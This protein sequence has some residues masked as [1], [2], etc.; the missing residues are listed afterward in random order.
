MLLHCSTCG[1]ELTGR[2]VCSRCGT[3]VGLEAGLASLRNRLQ[4][5]LD[6]GVLA[7]RGALQ[8]IHFLW[9]CALVPIFV[10]P[11]CVSLVMA[12][13]AMR[14]AESR[15]ASSHEWVALVSALNIVVS[16]LFLYKL[17]FSPAEVVV[18]L[19]AWMRWLLNWITGPFAPR[20][21]SVKVTP[22]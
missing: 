12:V 17:H 20:P 14:G 9:A 15:S 4:R 8:P 19:S 16:L 13:K 5:R 1:A 7:F 18:W 2:T 11:P 3:L 10:L 22:V 6:D 21:P